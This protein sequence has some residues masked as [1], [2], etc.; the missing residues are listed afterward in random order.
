MASTTI[1][2]LTTA[3][4]PALTQQNCDFFDNTS[5]KIN[6][7]QSSDFVDDTSLN[8]NINTQRSFNLVDYTISNK[9]NN[10]NKNINTNFNNS[11]NIRT[12]SINQRSCHCWDESNSFALEIDKRTLFIKLANLEFQQCCDFVIVIKALLLKRYISLKFAFC[13]KGIDVICLRIVLNF[14]S[15]IHN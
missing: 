12:N 11:I 6:N 5:I 9:D 1:L 2:A 7:Q 4:T 10:I 14:S 15:R 13:Y 3:L 8:D